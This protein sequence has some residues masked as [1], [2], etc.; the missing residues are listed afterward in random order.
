MY[1]RTYVHTYKHAREH[2]LCTYTRKYALAVVYSI[3]MHICTH[4]IHAYYTYACSSEQ[5]YCFIILCRYIHTYILMHVHIHT[6]VHIYV[7]VY[8]SLSFLSVLIKLSSSDWYR[9]SCASI[10]DF[11]ALIDSWLL[12][13]CE[14][15]IL[16]VRKTKINTFT[17]I[18]TALWCKHSCK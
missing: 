12:F 7:N 13:S 9:S 1:I 15:V 8:I 18:Y 3:C 14:S 4:Y 17:H 5:W 6:Y 16:H 2:V 10:S 11:P